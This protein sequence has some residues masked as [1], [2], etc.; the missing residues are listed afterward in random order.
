MREEFFWLFFLTFGWL[1][2]VLGLILFPPSALK[3]AIR[4]TRHC[5]THR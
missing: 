5:E 2:V 1:P 4:L 3:C